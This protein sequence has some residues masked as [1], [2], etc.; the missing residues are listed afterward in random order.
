MRWACDAFNELYSGK[1]HG[2]AQLD[3]TWATQ[4]VAEYQ[5]TMVWR[6]EAQANYN[7]LCRLAVRSWH[8]GAEP[9]SEEQQRETAKRG[10][11]AYAR[12]AEAFA[13]KAQDIRDRRAAREEQSRLA[14]VKGERK[15]SAAI[16]RECE[17]W[18]NAAVA[19]QQIAQT[20][21]VPWADLGS[22]ASTLLDLVDKLRETQ[23][24]YCRAWDSTD[25]CVHREMS[26]EVS[27]ARRLAYNAHLEV[28]D[29][30][31]YLEGRGVASVR[32]AT[33]PAPL[34]D[35][36]DS[37]R[38]DPKTGNA[39]VMEAIKEACER[40]DARV[41]AKQDKQRATQEHCNAI[42]RANRERIERNKQNSTWSEAEGK[43][44]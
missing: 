15:R 14:M 43:W 23:A 39:G 40:E 16:A 6:K 17:Q 7:E 41:Q 44:V 36:L 34:S 32:Q 22:M 20:A 26:A 35:G 1:T 8:P 28:H 38:S 5:Q 31:N 12:H 10:D 37:S 29:T 9:P 30:L 33:L 19:A 4:W 42:M 11:A 27:E 21:H 3:S 13:R 18:Q 25:L 2:V 24:A